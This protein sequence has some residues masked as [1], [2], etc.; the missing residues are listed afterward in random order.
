MITAE[1]WGLDWI[2]REPGGRYPRLVVPISVVDYAG[3]CGLTADRL[4]LL[5][6]RFPACLSIW[7][8]ELGCSDTACASNQPLYVQTPGAPDVSG[9]QWV[10]VLSSYQCYQTDP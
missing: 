7:L 6:V 4:C 1:W 9:A 8:I 10:D 2:S 3:W 5:H